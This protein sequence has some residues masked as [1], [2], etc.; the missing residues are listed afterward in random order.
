MNDKDTLII[1]IT[2]GIGSGKTSVARMFEGFGAKV[3][4]ADREASALMHEDKEVKAQLIREFGKDIYDRDGALNRK[5]MSDMVF[6]ATDESRER[7]GRLNSIVH[8]AVIEKMIRT[9]ETWS[10]EGEKLI[11]VESA[12]IY[13]AELDEGFDYIILVQSP[14]D[15]VIK[16]I[17]GERGLSPDE[18][19]NRMDAQIP[20]EEKA[21]VAD[22]V[23]DN[24]GT[25]DELRNSARFIF[26][27][28]SNMPP[29][30]K[31]E[32]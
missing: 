30:D 32:S 19:V 21:G 22:F 27:I 11:A 12:L 6:D 23:I 9:L 15:A 3:F 29:V 7:L 5:Y 31:K 2:G 10:Q 24:K 18:I 25:I 20:N 1:G 26:D 28:V 8:P 16:R 17:S 13:E 4:Y 14:K